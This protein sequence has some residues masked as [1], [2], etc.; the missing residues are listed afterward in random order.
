MAHPVK[1]SLGR[2]LQFRHGHSIANCG[3]GW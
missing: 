2:A 3:G 1:L